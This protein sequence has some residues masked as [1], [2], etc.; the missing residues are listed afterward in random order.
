[1]DE[2]PRSIGESSGM[3]VSDPV[4]ALVVY[5]DPA[6][7]VLIEAALGKRGIET[8]FA[9]TADVALRL[10]QESPHDILLLDQNPPGMPG[11]EISRRIRD[12][13][14]G[15]FPHIILITRK[16]GDDLLEQA[17]EAGIDDYLVKPLHGQTLG[18][19]LAI[20]ERRVKAAR[21]RREREAELARNAI[22]DPLTGLATRALL[23]DRVQGGLYRTGRETSYV[24]AV[25]QLDLDA[26]SRLNET[27]GKDGANAILAQA[28]RRVEAS[29]RSVDTA[30]RITADE[31]GIFLEDLKDAR[32]VTR[33]TDRLRERFAEPFQVEEQKVF[34]GCSI[35]IALGSRSY[36][37]PEE[38]FRDASRALMK[39]KEEGAGGVRIFDPVVHKQAS[40]R[41]ELETRI[42]QALERDEMVL[43]YQPI[44]S[45]APADPR[46]VGLEALIRWPKPG[47]GMVAPGEFIPVAERSGLI[48]HLGWWTI[49]H[50]CRQLLSW[51]GRHPDYPQLAVMVNIS[52]RQFSEPELAP[53]VLHILEGTGLNG[54]HLHLEITESSAMADLERSV[55]T[56]HALKTLGVHLHVDDFGTGYSSLSYIHRFPL[57]SLKVDRSFVSGMTERPENVA[58]VRTV[59]GLARSLGLSVVVEGIETEQQL[60]IAREM[61][62]EYAQGWLFAK[63]MEAEAVE[64]VLSI[65]DPVLRPLRGNG[66]RPGPGR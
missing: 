43:H 5:D 46:I 14:S 66:G 53:S 44:V 61:G 11:L 45:L 59:V 38:V 9:G 47:G 6:S 50:A 37:D 4:R 20:A 15:D 64:R 13:F 33:V 1:V 31:F 55:E 58:I 41:V 52:G 60:A 21:V 36:S 42:R 18:I 16:G 57:D 7:R 28:A 25:L 34:V 24:F 22:T 8:E 10:F 56:F 19:R 32:D 54:D 2:E 51:H 62:C 3:S 27:L 23:R 48:N 12:V 17:L 39:A 40:A 30:A 35:G 65:P 49:E 26:F 29:I 63:A